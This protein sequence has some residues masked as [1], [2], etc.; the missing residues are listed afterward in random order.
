VILSIHQPSYFP[1]L[2]LLDKISKSS[3][4]MVMD[5]VQLLERGFQHRNLFLDVDGAT[6]FLTIPFVRKDYV[7]K[8]LRELQIASATWRRK[9]L[10][11]LRN[12]YRKHPYAEEIMPRIESFYAGDYPLLGDALVASMRLSL[13]LFGI[14]TKIVFQSEM[15]YDRSLRRGELVVAL[16]RAAGASCYLSGTG[17]QAYLDESAFGADLKLRYN[18]FEHPVYAQKRAPKFQSGLACLDVLL[19]LGMQ[20]ARAL[21]HQQRQPGA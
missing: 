7:N 12:S 10:N 5:E 14:D 17:A 15:D 19:N 8:P 18:H 9:H 2:G 20:G 4:F 3:V 11:F 21:L 13:D 1:W 16:A 6:R